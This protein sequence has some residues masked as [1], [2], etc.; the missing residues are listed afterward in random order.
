M[1][2][3]E[4]NVCKLV[5]SLYGIKQ[6]PKQLHEKFDCHL[7]HGFIHKCIYSKF[8]NCYSVITCL[9]VD[10]LLIFGTN[11]EGI[12]K[13]KKHLTSKFKMKDLK[14]VDTIL[15]VKVKKYM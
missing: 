9:Y 2:G 1:P 6:A 4:K 7:S 5:K 14:K 10:D 15:G 13:T 8:T 3:N 12:T 11:I